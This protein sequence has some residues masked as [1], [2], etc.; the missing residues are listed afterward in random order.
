LENAPGIEARKRIEALLQQMSGPP[1]PERL[2]LDRALEA[3]EWIGTEEAAG[4]RKA[5]PAGAA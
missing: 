4:T 2:Q 5:E 3:V 1:A